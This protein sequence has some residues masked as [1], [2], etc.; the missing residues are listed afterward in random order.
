MYEQDLDQLTRRVAE[1]LTGKRVLI[2]VR[3]PAAYHGLGQ[4]YKTPQG[5]IVIDIAP[6]ESQ[7]T[8]F[9]LL[10]HELAHIC[11]D[12]DWIPATN[13][14]KRA[15]GSVRKTQGERDAWKVN[16]HETAAHELAFEW[17]KYAEDNA[18]KF[19]VVGRSVQEC[20]LRALLDWR[21]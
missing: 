12:F 5:E 7:Q 3:Q 19:W 21:E 13:D 16:P 14:H 4:V 15:P 18:Y 9:E 11:L 6:V 17:L 10:V 2:R 20:K 8:R 1:H